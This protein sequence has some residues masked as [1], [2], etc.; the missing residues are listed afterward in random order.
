MAKFPTDKKGIRWA[1]IF[2]LILTGVVLFYIYQIQKPPIP[3]NGEMIERDHG[4][5]IIYGKNHQVLMQEILVQ[6]SFVERKTWYPTGKPKTEIHFT[7][8]FLKDVL[9]GEKVEW[10]ENGI[11]KSHYFFLNDKPNGIIKEWFPSGHLK[12][13]GF[14]ENGNMCG[15]YQEWHA[16]GL[17]AIQGIFQ[18]G[19]KQGVWT[20]WDSTGKQLRT[21][22]HLKK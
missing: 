16:T 13:V 9:N 18:F 17:P 1:T 5:T 21:E 8:S 14:Y 10:Y 15:R 3:E 7:K 6:D 19:Q 2:A 11:K 20:Y 4:R 12:K 22:N